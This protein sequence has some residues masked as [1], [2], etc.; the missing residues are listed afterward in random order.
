MGSTIEIND[1]LKLTLEEGLPLNP[2][3]GRVYEFRKAGR[4]LY[5]LTPARVFLVE[6][7]GGKWN[8]VGQAQVAELTIDAGRN[9]TRGRFVLSKLYPRRY[10]ELMNQHDAPEGKGC[11]VLD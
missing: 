9:E 8:F 11:V 2:E 1:T 5:H 6:D 10:A 7:R 3:E 4:R